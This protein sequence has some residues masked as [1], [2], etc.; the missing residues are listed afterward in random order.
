MVE[1]MSNYFF[2]ASGWPPGVVGSQS[3]LCCPFI[4]PLI[5]SYVTDVTWAAPGPL[6]HIYR[7]QQ[8]GLG[9]AINFRPASC[10]SP[11]AVPGAKAM[12]A[13]LKKKMDKYPGF[14]EALADHRLAGRPRPL[15]SCISLTDSM[16][17]WTNLLYTN[18]KIH[19]FTQ[20]NEH[21]GAFIKIHLRDRNH[22]CRL[23]LPLPGTPHPA[24][25]PSLLNYRVLRE[26]RQTG[27]TSCSTWLR[28]IHR[29]YHYR[30][31]HRRLQHHGVILTCSAPSCWL[32]LSPTQQICINRKYGLGVAEMVQPPWRINDLFL[33]LGAEGDP[34]GLGQIL[35]SLEGRGISTEAAWERLFRCS[36]DTYAEDQA[37]KLWMSRDLRWRYHLCSPAE[38][39]GSRFRYTNAQGRHRRRRPCWKVRSCRSLGRTVNRDGRA[40]R[41]LASIYFTN[42]FS[43]GRRRRTLF[44]R[45]RAPLAFSLDTGVALWVDISAGTAPF[46]TSSVPRAPA[47]RFSRYGGKGP[48]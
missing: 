37:Q 44:E 25:I 46:P 9:I 27:P 20:I 36:D 2:R 43:G 15:L 3:I 11:F 29:C 26:T 7:H 13:C 16:K 33:K 32:S 47:A 1:N 40:A 30:F 38:G 12:H 42:V 21:I 39:P 34:R 41:N 23:Q 24:P 6:F 14:R 22:R 35:P 18:F 31:L 45:P 10:V 19:L 4:T 5:L 8:H 28:P 17:A 48:L